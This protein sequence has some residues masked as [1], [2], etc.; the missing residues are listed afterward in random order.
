MRNGN[1]KWLDYG[2]WEMEMLNG[3]GNGKWLW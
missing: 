2:K 3:Y 1:G